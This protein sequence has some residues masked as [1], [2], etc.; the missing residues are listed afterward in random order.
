MTTHTSG[1]S[2]NSR[3]LKVFLCHSSKDKAAVRDLYAKLRASGFAPWLDEEDLLPGQNWKRVIPEAVRS[4]DVVLV[5]LSKLSV[6]TDGYVHQ[7]I[8]FALEAAA[9]KPDGTIF[10]I[11]ARLDESPIPKIIADLHRVDLFHERGFARLI[12]VLNTQAATVGA[13]SG[14]TLHARSSDTPILQ[15]ASLQ[16][17]DIARTTWVGLYGGLSDGWPRAYAKTLDRDDHYVAFSDRTVLDERNGLMWAREDCGKNVTWYEA[18]QY[19]ETYTCGGYADW[20]MPTASELGTLFDTTRSNRQG[21]PVTRLIDS[22]CHDI[23]AADELGADARYFG[24]RIGAALY[25]KKVFAILMFALPVRT[26]M[27]PTA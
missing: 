25:Q 12:N 11:P 21:A 3:L 16:Q 4:A 6:G 13:R 26:A 18:K 20:R 2:G 9:N 14:T 10:I 23:W 5:C 15:N 24:F 1:E 17:P 19:C 7:E 27:R 8:S 22:T